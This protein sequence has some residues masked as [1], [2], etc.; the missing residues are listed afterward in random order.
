MAT[1]S[2]TNTED[3]IIA[4]DE[5]VAVRRGRKAEVNSD[6]LALLKKIPAGKAA[7]LGGTFGTV[8]TGSDRQRVSGI[9]RRHARMAWGESADFAVNYSP[10]GVPQITHK[11]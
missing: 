5:V 11:S 2:K 8:P 4:A 1:N 3:Q 9:I 10:E 6:L 7:R